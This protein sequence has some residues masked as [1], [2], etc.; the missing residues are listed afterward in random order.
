VSR[1]WYIVNACLLVLG[2]LGGYASLAPESIS[3][4]NPDAVL[5]LLVIVIIPV[6]FIGG[7]H[8][9]TARLGLRELHTP[10]WERNPLLFWYDPLQFLFVA[11]LV[12]FAATIGSG[13]RSWLAGWVGFWIF[14]LYCS[15]VIGLVI[16]RILI[17]RLFRSR[18]M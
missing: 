1:I 10:S 15:M 7:I 17:Y 3:G 5:C 16:A 4:S 11:T 12:C 13:F 14:G 8:Y 2:L 9:G 18:I 6:V